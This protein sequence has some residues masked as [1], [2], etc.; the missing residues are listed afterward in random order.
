MRSYRAAQIND[1]NEPTV[2]SPVASRQTKRSA[3]SDRPA[4][5]THVT[6]AKA[7]PSPTKPGS[8][9][10]TAFITVSA[11]SSPSVRRY[12]HIL[13]SPSWR[14]ETFV[15]QHGQAEDPF[16]TSGNALKSA[17]KQGQSRVSR[18]AVISY[19]SWDVPL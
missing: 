17:V 10:N 19:S 15:R 13:E 8:G 2:E 18:I 5:T 14:R 1:S 11:G 4:D 6:F 12:Q 7:S 3:Q 16:T 9:G